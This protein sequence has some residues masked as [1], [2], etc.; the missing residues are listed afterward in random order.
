M[1]RAACTSSIKRRF[2]LPAALLTWLGLGLGAV[3]A[4]GTPVAAAP[5]G[6][7]LSIQAG[8]VFDS[9]RGEV[10]AGRRIVIHGGRKY[11]GIERA[12]FLVDGDGVIRQ[13]WRKVKVTGH[14]AA[15]LKAA[16]AL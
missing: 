2:G 8:A 13:A 15:V 10:L 5:A 12:T 7:D 11:M 1:R 4:A 14:V 3:L 6:R 16:Q 9:V